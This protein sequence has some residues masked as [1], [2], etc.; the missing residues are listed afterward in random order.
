MK[1]RAGESAAGRVEGDHVPWRPLVVSAAVAL[2]VA[3]LGVAVAQAILRAGSPHGARVTPARAAREIGGI[4]QTLFATARDGL[5]E[6]DRQRDSLA[7]YGWVDRSN[8]IARIPI[9]RA[10]DLV[11]DPAFVAHAVDTR[12]DAGAGGRP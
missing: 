8:G 2:V 1:A 6:R 11:T 7:R 12:A 10:I 9:D 3:V 5:D 4:E